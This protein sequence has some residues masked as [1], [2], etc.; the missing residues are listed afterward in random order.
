M[1]QFLSLFFFALLL[2]SATFA[3]QP[4]PI[5]DNSFLIEEAYN[6][7]EGIVQHVN[8]FV[9]QRTGDW[10]YS[11]TQEWPLFSH[12][13]QLSFTLPAQRSGGGGGGGGDLPVRGVSDLALSY[14]YQLVDTKKVA[15]A[16]RFSL[17][18]PIG[19]S[20]RGLGAGAL[21]WQ[22]NLPISVPHGKRVV[23]HWNA[24][25][26][27][28]PKRQTHSASGPAQPATIS[29]KALSCWFHPTSMC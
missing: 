14:R 25:A 5:L 29:A 10:A 28:T 15:I 2:A 18:A 21:G 7:D 24:G 13:H 17:L 27:F 12:K 4:A 19:D 26:T 1:R 9:R 6:Q 16:P 23:T 11:F 20:T 8:T 3:Q 22:A